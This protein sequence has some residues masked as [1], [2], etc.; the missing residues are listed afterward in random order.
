MLPMGPEIGGPLDNGSPHNL[1]QVSSQQT[2]RSRSRHCSVHSTSSSCVSRP[3]EPLLY[4]SV[5]KKATH[6]AIVILGKKQIG[7]SESDWGLDIIFARLS[8]PM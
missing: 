2:V 6:H 1:D 5:A 8:I 3:L 7:K 4:L